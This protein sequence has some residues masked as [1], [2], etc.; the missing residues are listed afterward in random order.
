MA[1]LIKR[2]NKWWC[3]FKRDDK[4]CREATPYAVNDANGK[5]DAR[6]K[7]LAKNYADALQRGIAQRG[8]ESLLGP[9]T[10]KRYAD[11]WLVRRRE[12]DLDW[13]N[14]AGRLKHHVY[15]HIGDMPIA[16]VRPR[17]LI[18]M[19]HALRTKPAKRTGEVLAQRTIYNIYSVVSALFRDAKL[20]EE[21]DQTP[22]ELDERQ[23]GPLTDKD[24]EWRDAAVFT[25]EEAETLISDPRIPHDR[26]M[27]YAFMLLA[28][29]RPGETSAL[30][31]RHYDA[32]TSPL[33]K[34]TVAAAYNT[35]K[36]R[37][38][39]TKTETVRHVPV[40]PVLA[41]MLAEWR[42]SGWSEMMGRK[43]E[44]DD[45]I[46][47]L[48]PLAA[49]MRRSREGEAYRSGDY[50]GKRWREED[51]PALGWRYRSP[52]DMKST[53]I[54][55]CGEDGA[56]DEIIESRVTHTK[57]SRNAYDGYRRNRGAQWARTCAE[58]A[59]LQIRRVPRVTG[60]VTALPVTDGDQ[61]WRRRESSLAAFFV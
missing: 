60:R 56:D 2:G 39:G 53:F 49:S 52:Y 20:D 11:A 32:T 44:S 6:M 13:K 4:W 42:L 47:P 16:S 51:A 15:P 21:I 10:V 59:K 37:E 36:N 7:K 50:L 31:W 25:R 23:L 45:L 19:F 5:P 57:R 22:C 33:G 58:V 43:P 34:L 27:V 48:P 9:L 38:K 3:A 46:V 17:H 12:S 29:M 26:Q 14:D 28:G 54:T 24:P 41:A 30:R 18:A 35:R 8:A 61:E 1:Y 55:L 40:H